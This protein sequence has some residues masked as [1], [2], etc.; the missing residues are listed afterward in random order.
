MIKKI[1]K[2]YSKFVLFNEFIDEK[3]KRFKWL[4]ILKDNVVLIS[5]L[6]VIV[7]I[8]HGLFLLV[9]YLVEVFF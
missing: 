3:Y 7:G 1:K 2:I 5:Q 6:L 4:L 9:S 8:I